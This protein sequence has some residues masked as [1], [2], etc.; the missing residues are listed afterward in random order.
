MFLLLN[1][2]MVRTYL[3]TFDSAH[4][5]VECMHAYGQVYDMYK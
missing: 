2:T 3:A 4:I 5:I 1:S